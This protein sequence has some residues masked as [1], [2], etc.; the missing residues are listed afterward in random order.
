M[1][2][3]V[4]NFLLCSNNVEIKSSPKYKMESVGGVRRLKIQSPNTGDEISCSVGKL[5]TTTKLESEGKNAIF[6]TQA[7]F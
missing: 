6:L 4:L 7:L 2:I 5:S 3:R 1:L